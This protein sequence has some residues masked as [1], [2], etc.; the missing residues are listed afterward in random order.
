MGLLEATLGP[1]GYAGDVADKLGGRA[2]RGALG[3]KARELASVI[4]FSDSLGITRP[5][6]RVS[7]RD[8]TDQWGVTRR[9]DDSLASHLLGAGTEAAL[10]PLTIAGGLAGAAGLRKLHGPAGLGV[11]GTHPGT[12]EIGQVAQHSGGGLLRHLLGDETGAVDFPRMFGDRMPNPHQQGIIAHAEGRLSDP[13]LAVAAVNQGPRYEGGTGKLLDILTQAKD[14]ELAHA[15]MANILADPRL[16]ERVAS[17]I[18]PGSQ[19]LGAGVEAAA[20]KSPYGHVVR[21]TKHAGDPVTR[22]NVPEMVQPFRS[23][24][25]GGHTIEHMPYVQPMESIFDGA[26]R[27]ISDLHDLADPLNPEHVAAL[28]HLHVGHSALSEARD[29][30]ETDIVKALNGRGVYDTDWHDGN[31]GFTNEGKIAAFDP[32]T[33]ATQYG[34]DGLHDPKRFNWPVASVPNPAGHPEF[35]ALAKARGKAA[36]IPELIREEII[37]GAEAGTAAFGGAAPHTAEV[38]GPSILKLIEGIRSRHKAG[39]KGPEAFHRFLAESPR[40]PVGLTAPELYKAHAQSGFAR[41]MP[42]EYLDW[43]AGRRVARSG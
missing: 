13:R 24:V 8:L 14:P 10:D 2:L 19:Y 15:Q 18:A 34:T 21:I 25:R 42:L 23:V 37:K 33:L 29:L 4:P 22:V 28:D 7:G 6:D 43:L 32:G 36:G 40:P 17:E 39:I 16:A 31:V 3:G 5:G 26:F 20:F 30:D 35:N 1:V 41:G 38:D 9:G 27:P 11:L 12:G